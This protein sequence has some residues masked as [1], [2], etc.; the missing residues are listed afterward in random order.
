[1]NIEKSLTNKICLVTGAT[2][3]IG[4]VTVEALAEKG[5]TVIIVGRYPKKSKSTVNRIRQKTG[6]SSIEFMLADLSSQEEIH[7][8]AEQF[9][10]KYQR[11]DVL[12]NNAGAYFRSRHL[13][14][15][16]YEMTFALNHLGY[17]LLTNLL[18]NTLK[19]S[20]PARIINVSSNAHERGRINFEDLQRQRNY[21]GFE[22]YAQSKLAN[23]LFTYELA[24]RLKGTGI[25]VNALHPG[26]V[27]TNLGRNNGWIRHIIKRLVKRKLISPV[28]GA[29]TS[30]YLATSKDVQGVTGKYFV[31]SKS[32][33]S[34][35][36]SYDEV[37][38]HQLWK[39]S[40]EMTGL[41]VAKI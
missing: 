11:L 27:A 10:K 35:K 1:M 19:A 6:N 36:T 15:D 24:K 9:K 39:V 41:P 30:I 33:P 17:F 37:L 3:G 26:G 7:C 12:I 8:L 18:L 22:V 13:S 23:I 5:A 28:D 14:V 21:H 40:A 34:S 20:V 25:T 16:G 32:V 38:G 29:Q 4:A 2:S 31:K